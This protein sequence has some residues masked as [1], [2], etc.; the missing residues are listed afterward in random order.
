[1]HLSM[2]ALS[3]IVATADAGSVSGSAKQMNVSQP[4]IS[5][6]IAQ[7]E[8]TIGTA[9]F[10]RHHARGMTTTAAGQRFINEARILLTHARDFA[11]SA[12][13]LTSEVSGEVTVG[14]FVTLAT[15]FMPGILAEFARRMPG[16]A[17]NLEEGNQQDIIEGVTSGRLELAMAYAYAVPEEV[18]GEHLAELPPYVLVSSEHPLA[19]RGEISLKEIGH[20]PFILL[21]LPFSRDYFFNLFMACGIEPRVAYRSR[22]PELIRGLVGHGCGYTVHNALPGTNLSYDG[23]KIIALKIT[24]R[25][26]P[27]HVVTLRLR[28][29]NVRPAVQLFADFMREAFQPN[30]LF[31]LKF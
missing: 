30:G 20:E 8:A 26:A 25:P 15:R 12:E 14:S 10:V 7:I 11:R 31:P 6:A 2:R 16:I 4:S 1:M 24:E 21:D 28:R 22:S 3:Y 5:A 23:R 27:V 17:I 18:V 13:A 19:E 29:Q 9:L